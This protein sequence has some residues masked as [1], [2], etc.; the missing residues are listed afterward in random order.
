M[1]IRMSA[2]GALALGAILAGS[3]WAAWAAPSDEAQIRALEKQFAAAVQAKDPAKIMA[4]YAPEGLFVFDLVPPRQYVGQAA[5]K[6]DW[7]NVFAGTAGPVKFSV[8]DLAVTVV[9]PVAYG[10]SIQSI[11]WT[12]KNGKP[13]NAVVRVSD[14]YRKMAGKW[15]IVQEHVSVPV[16]LDT[17]KPDMTSKP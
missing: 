15:L 10:H 12:G 1:S 4:V 17:G 13:T 16:D 2:A 5:Y 14:V 7:E 11:G 8:A 6:K 3:A 9:G